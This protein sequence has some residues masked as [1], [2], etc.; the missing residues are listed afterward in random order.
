MN[1]LIV[2]QYFF[3][4][5]FIINDLVVEMEKQ[6]HNVTVLTGKPNYPDGKIFSGY[7]ASGVVREKYAEDVEIVRVP[8]RPRGAGG[9]KNL[10][11]NYLSFVLFGC[12]LGPWLLRKKKFDVSFVFVPSPI[13]GAFPAMVLKG[14]TGTPI[15]LWVLDLW[16]QSLVVTKFVKNPVLLKAVEAMV[17]FIYR[18]CDSVLVQ[19]K[20]FIEPVKKIDSKCTPIYYP[21]SFKKMSIDPTLTLP[22]DAENA[23]K[24]H[25]SVVFAGNIGKAQSVETI[26]AAAKLL[27]DLPDLKIVF[28]GSGSMLSWIQDKIKI[29]GLSNIQCLGRFDISY[30]P[31]I[32]AQ[33]SALLLTLNADEILKYTLPWKTQ[34]Y[35]AAGKPIIGAIDGEGARTILEAEC[36]LCG[37]A[38]DAQAL[39]DNIRRMYVMDP[40]ELEAMGNRGKKYYE[41]NFEMTTQTTRLINILRT[42]K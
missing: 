40:L 39:A 36:G 9:A 7:K 6:G 15:A 1:I 30:I 11:L 38:E 25:F 34:S 10:I 2:T 3:P 21:N 14:L 17:W 24:K 8:L 16:P 29:D 31:L 4:E 20:S 33:S 35:M 18:C 28:V 26:V 42:T 19:S 32:Y 23:L 27:Q 37:P 13:T 12:L 41:D 22:L 5:T